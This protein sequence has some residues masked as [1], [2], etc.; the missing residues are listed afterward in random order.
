MDPTETFRNP[1]IKGDL[2]AVEV[3]CP[4]VSERPLMCFVIK[5]NEVRDGHAKVTIDRDFLAT[6]GSWADPAPEHLPPSWAG[7]SAP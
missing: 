3:S 6:V 7:E 2:L 5:L 4:E 1:F